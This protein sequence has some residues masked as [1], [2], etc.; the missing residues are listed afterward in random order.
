MVM[1]FDFSKYNLR[2][3][4]RGHDGDVRGICVC[5]DET[6]ATSSRD[7]TIRVWS[8]DPFDERVYTSS[9]TLL[10]H[11]NLVGPLA[12]FPPNEEYPQGRLVSGS[13]DTSIFVWNLVNGENIQT[14]K[15]HAMEVTGVTVDNE[16]IVSASV[17]Q[18][19]KRWREGKLVECWKTHRSPVQTVLKLPSGELV[20]G[21]CDMSL[22]LWNGEKVLRTFTGHT[23]TVRGLAVFPE[24][25]I[26]SASH[27]GLLRLWNHQ[28][29][30]CLVMRGHTSRVYSVDARAS[31]HIVSGSEDRLAKIWKDGAC[32]QSLEHPGFVWDAKFLESG[33][34][35]TA[36][37]DGVVRIWTARDGMIAD[38]SEIDA[39]YGK[40]SQHRIT[41]WG[42]NLDEL[43][44]VDSLSLPCL[45]DG[46]EKTIKEGNNGVTYAWSMLKQRW[47]KK[48]R[49]ADLD[50]A[51]L[52]PIVEVSPAEIDA[53]VD[54]M[55]AICG[56]YL[57]LVQ[58]EK[59]L[60]PEIQLTEVEKACNEKK[61][62][63]R[64]EI[65]TVLF[66][67]KD[68]N[69]NEEK[70]PLRWSKSMEIDLEDVV[71]SLAKKDKKPFQIQN[72]LKKVDLI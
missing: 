33:D 62:R 51:D 42:M 54:S 17:D 32:L 59:T 46:E 14:L 23:G 48:F 66:A 44:E 53:K 30:V 58:Q 57:Q 70:T 20:S 61:Q 50:A 7:R 47:G 72:M 28:G 67:G 65:A 49:T 29:E 56:E 55:L 6:I 10:G 3:E 45:A 8:V 19:L 22:K 64:R 34:I 60:P 9:K 1:D 16:D 11:T 26:L 43:P 4:L 36:C 52:E 69:R 68:Q 41:L 18:T 21:S 12:C 40:I 24:N 37:S 15:G 63:L 2:C 71:I 39:F 27:D 13:M 31:G 38:Q 35:V 25:Q 5:N